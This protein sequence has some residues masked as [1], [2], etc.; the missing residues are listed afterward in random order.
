MNQYRFNRMVSKF[1]DKGNGDV[2]NQMTFYGKDYNVYI[3]G[4]TRADGRIQYTAGVDLALSLGLKESSQPLGK[5]PMM[6][7]TGRIVG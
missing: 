7:Y 2:D 6:Y 1:E 4:T 3:F 5:L